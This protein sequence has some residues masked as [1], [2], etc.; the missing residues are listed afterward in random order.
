MYRI[1]EGGRR[2]FSQ[3]LCMLT[4]LALGFSFPALAQNN[5]AGEI[6]GT[7]TTADGAIVVSA[8]VTITNTQTGVTTVVKTDSSGLYDV[9]SLVPGNYEAKVVSESF[10]T[11]VQQGIVLRAAP[12]TVNA[13]L[14][15][16][17]VTQ[18]VTVS[19]HANELQTENATQ[20]A[21]LE[22]ETVTG[23][24][25]VGAYWYNLLAL[26]PGVNGGGNQ[27]TNGQDAVGVNG[28]E[29]NQQSILLNGGT[30]I[31]IG[32]QNASGGI[33]PDD[34][35]SEMQF[36]TSN[37]TAEAGNGTSVFNIITKSGTNHFHGSAYDY[38]Q[39]SSL[40]ARNYF[41]ANVPSSHSNQYGGTIGGPVL[42]NKLFFFFGY[43]HLGSTA[44]SQGFAT[45][46]TTAERGGDFSA[47]STPIYDPAT[48]R[49]V[50]GQ[51]VRD[52]FPGNMIPMDRISTQAS[53]IQGY[54]PKSNLSGTVNNYSYSQQVFDKTDWFNAK[55][56]Y[57]ISPSNHLNGSLM[58]DRLNFPNPSFTNPIGVFTEFGK[59]QIYQISDT[60]AISPRV[61]N[62]ARFSMVRFTGN[63]ISGD[64]NKG[65]P[66]KLGI[67]NSVS[68]V[69]P[70]INISGVISTGF[71]HQLDAILAETT[72][73]PSDVMTIVRGKHILKFGGEWDKY[74]ININFGGESDGNFGF[75]GISTRNP[76]DGTSSGI[77]YAD[78][79]LG[80]VANWS[81]SIS[82]ETGG[83]LSSIHTFFQDDFKALPNLTFNLGVRYQIQPGWTEVNNKL[84]DFDPTLTNPATNTPGAL[85]FAG[86]NGRTALQDTQHGLV[87]P[88][89]GF[90]WSPKNR[91]SVRG[92][93]GTFY[94]LYGY[95]TYGGPQGLGYTAQNST[96]SSDNRT[97]VFTL[98]Q[99]PPLPIYPTDAI[100]T[101]EL[102]NGQSISYIPYHTPSA[103]AEQWQ[104]DVQHE[105]P[106]A[107]LVD[108]AYVGS[109]SVHETLAG[110]FNQVPES[111]IYHA[112]EGADMQQ[113]RPHTQY[114]SIGTTFA[115]GYSNYNSLQARVQRRYANGFQ[116]LTNFTY[117]HT[118]DNGTGSG[119]GGPGARS[120]LWQN[121]YDTA[122]T[123]GNSLLDMRYVLNGDAIYDLPVGKGRH[124]VNHPGVLDELI[125]GWQASTLFQIHSGIPFTPYIGTA[126]LDGS[127]AG[128]WFPNRVAKGT[129]PHPTIQQWFDT[130]AF[131]TPAVGTYGNSGRDI[132]YGPAWRT[133]DLS[134]GKHFAIPLLGEASNFG[135]RID[136]T[137][138]FNHPNF[139]NPNTAIGTGTAGTITGANTSRAVQLSGKLVF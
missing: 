100:R 45:V 9:P 123:Y 19:E 31:L 125:G 122:A 118:L 14:Q 3:T 32:S 132:L 61:V 92:A 67:P 75:T 111:L 46:P 137:D 73:A 134:L 86:R 68:N 81:I 63:W 18:Q 53:A 85:W 95:N 78:F 105:F 8:Q 106:G 80:D 69:F 72:F 49:L 20:S 109:R 30:A 71:G 60:W 1:F 76:A 5:D 50:D 79:L 66:E 29:A 90:A 119:Y 124:F 107:L 38:N 41:S 52:P 114:Q 10:Q 34:F 13:V 98:A 55:V 25:N 128:A 139:G 138:V 26:V 126:N 83:R 99:G 22:T 101:P 11:F 120:S 112:A 103:Y 23:V 115:G 57:Q 59:D 88:R 117:S 58:N 62:E 87:M 40:N 2:S 21:T 47:L 135:I 12:I 16:G 96:S 56:D 54:L 7:V 4:L 51:Y 97:A 82:P 39:S 133:V 64:L 44:G 28:I 93:F 27:R 127:L 24:P 136:A 36:N 110:D 70:D 43:Q 121:T 42:R 17:S 65:Y 102:L 108:V 104:L 89:F 91:W 6:R 48:T 131:V 37:V 84:G 77:G 15:V 130:S 94:E 35:I 33:G 74:Q 116:F 129:L 113:Y